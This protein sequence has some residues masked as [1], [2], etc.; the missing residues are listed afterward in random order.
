MVRVLHV[1]DSLSVGGAEVLTVNILNLLSKDSR[2]KANIY[3]TR[4][5]GPL[6]SNINTQVDYIFLEKKSILDF[7]F[8]RN[9]IKN[10]KKNKID[11]IHTHN[12]SYFSCVLVKPFLPK[13]V[14]LIWHNHTGAYVGLSGLKFW[15][16]KISSLF[17]DAVL[18]VNNELNI[19]SEKKLWS[20]NN[21]VLNNFAF[22]SNEDKTTKLRGE[23]GKRIV[24]L[25]GLRPV[26]DHES[27]IKSFELV[28]QNHPDW[29][30][31]LIGKN[32]EDEYAGKIID[33]ILDRNLEE[34]IFFYGLRHDIKNIL[35]QSTIGTL[36]SKWE[37]FPI[38]VLEY[39]LAKLP[40]VLTNV[41]H[42]R[43]LIENDRALVAPN[44]YLELSKKIM[45]MIEDESLRETV[46]EKL[47]KK[48][49]SLF[50]E[51]YFMNELKSIYFK[52]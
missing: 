2:F 36:T 24:C 43:K 16:L 34:S 10:I 35:N 12:T 13:R 3:V 47:S 31:H 32:Y 41:G 7:K 52:L 50:S 19:W 18:N 38:C 48:V 5:E 14:K 1:L 40:V 6:K 4:K 20:K 22:F 15:V 42:N 46:S 45:E 39:G 8:Y 30:L 21:F 9:L 49:T 29:T 51:D 37:G 27:L 11:I 23:K 28:L 17:F 26:K 25:A 33:S 44:N